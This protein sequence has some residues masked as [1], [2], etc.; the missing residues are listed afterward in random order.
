MIVNLNKGDLVEL[1]NNI[2]ARLFNVFPVT[3]REVSC[4]LK[5]IASKRFFLKI[6][7]R[8]DAGIDL[9]DYR[10]DT[11]TNNKSHLAIYPHKR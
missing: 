4:I 10:M 6:F 1:P 7:A 8:T 11:M 2:T 3:T 5:D 9:G